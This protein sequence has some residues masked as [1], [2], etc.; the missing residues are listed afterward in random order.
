MS[1]FTTAGKIMEPFLPNQSIFPLASRVLHYRSFC[2]A[3]LRRVLC[4]VHGR[5]VCSRFGLHAG[6]YSD[7]KQPFFKKKNAVGRFSAFTA[8]CKLNYSAHQGHCHHI[9][10]RMLRC[11]TKNRMKMQ[12][13]TL[14]ARSFLISLV[15]FMWTFKGILAVSPR[16]FCISF[17]IHTSEACPACKHV[18]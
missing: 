9:Y 4:L 3:S 7:Q 14:S 18:F 17:T 16:C 10:T 2:F 11:F 12:K 5:S 8:S 13:Q 1:H 15:F 6:L